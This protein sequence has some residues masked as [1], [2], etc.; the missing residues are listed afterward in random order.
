VDELA[1]RAYCFVGPRGPSGLARC[2]FR[3]VLMSYG[4]EKADAKL[5]LHDLGILRAAIAQCAGLL[6]TWELFGGA[7]D[8]VIGV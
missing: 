2:N 1:R 8:R 4:R 3:N 7:G 6:L 5:V